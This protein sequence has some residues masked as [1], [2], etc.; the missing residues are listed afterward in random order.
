MIKEVGYGA[1][2]LLK[3]HSEIIRPERVR[4]LRQPLIKEFMSVTKRGQKPRAGKEP[5]D[6][7]KGNNVN[8]SKKSRT[9]RYTN[10][11]PDPS[12]D[13]EV[14]IKNPP[15]AGRIFAE[16]ISVKGGGNGQPIYWEWK[17]G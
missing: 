10:P 6:E 2:G 5:D 16:F 12:D 14:V 9:S 3:L 7:H 1:R 11:D 13:E 15:S 4:S 8:K 17:A